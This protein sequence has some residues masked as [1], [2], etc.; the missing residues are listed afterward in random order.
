MSILGSEAPDRSPVRRHST[1]VPLTNCPRTICDEYIRNLNLPYAYF[2]PS[3]DECYC[4]NHYADTR[5]KRQ[6][7]GG[8]NY[9]VP[10]GW[11]LFAL[12][13]DA[14]FTRGKLI[15]Q[16]WATSYYGVSED[17][18]EP[19]L[20]N[21]LI[22]LPDDRLSDEKI[23]SAFI[24]D[25]N[26]HCCTSPSINYISERYRDLKTRFRSQDGN[27]YEMQII[28]QCKQQPDTFEKKK[29]EANWCQIMSR[30]EIRWESKRRSTIVPCGIMVRA[31]RFVH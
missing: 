13:I 21:R 5:P 31:R 18:L 9:T 29:G 6:K 8:H 15:F 25:D 26:D 23:F 14:A 24:P 11:M 3:H 22:P 4:H 30:N 1:P 2:N 7:V 16:K 17:K 19:I 12:K 27:S 20:R 28:L 10:C